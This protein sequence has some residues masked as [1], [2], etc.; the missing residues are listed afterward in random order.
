MENSQTTIDIKI[1]IISFVNMK[2]NELKLN[3]TICVFY[4]YHVDLLSYISLKH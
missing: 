3:K 2:L 1:I 4:N